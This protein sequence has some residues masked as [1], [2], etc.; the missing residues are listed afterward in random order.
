MHKIKYEYM[1]QKATPIIC[2]INASVNCVTLNQTLFK[3]ASRT[4][5][6]LTGHWWNYTNML[7]CL[8]FIAISNT[9]SDIKID[10]E[11]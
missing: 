8:H 11:W 7:L 4:Q 9:T 1:N 6:T 5:Y 2:S 10:S 3:V